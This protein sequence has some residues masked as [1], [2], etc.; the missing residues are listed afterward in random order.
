LT[1]YESI[2][3]LH[4]ECFPKKPWSAE[5]FAGL[6][7][8]GCEIEASKNAFIVWRAAAD[9][10]EIVTIC[11]R[12]NARRSGAALALLSSTTNKLRGKNVKKI[13]LEVSADNAP[14]I[15]LYEKSGFSRIGVRPKYYA[16][17]DG[18]TMMKEL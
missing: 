15:K 10:A 7:K 4:A 9:E 11:V 1:D 14:A 13:F 17:T 6:E 5:D 18:I 2:S 3:E 16:G 8:S 12:P